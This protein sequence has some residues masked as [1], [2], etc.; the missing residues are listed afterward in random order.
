M[1]LTEY[2]N[3][4]GAHPETKAFYDTYHGDLVDDNNE[5]SH[6]QS[7][8]VVMS[9]NNEDGDMETEDARE[10]ISAKDLRAQLRAAAMRDEVSNLGTSSDI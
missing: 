10:T 5:F 8:D 9:S 2:D 4:S 1:T 6:M 7:E 3:L